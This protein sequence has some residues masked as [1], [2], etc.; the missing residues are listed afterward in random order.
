M[1]T[2]SQKSRKPK[3]P[4][5]HNQDTLNSIKDLNSGKG[6]CCDSIQDFWDKMGFSPTKSESSNQDRLPS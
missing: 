1:A 4:K 2:H 3:T 6:T 5:K